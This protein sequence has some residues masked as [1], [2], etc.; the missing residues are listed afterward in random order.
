VYCVVQVLPQTDQLIQC[1][2]SQLSANSKFF[3]AF[4]YGQSQKTMRTAIWDALIQLSQGIHDIWCVLGDF[5]SIL[6]VGDRVWR[7]DILS[8]KIRE[9][10]NHLKACELTEMISIGPYFWPANKT[11]LSR[12]GKAL[13]NPL[14]HGNFDFHQV[15]YVANRLS[16]HATLLISFQTAQNTG[17][18]SPFVTCCVV[19]IVFYNH[20]QIIRR[21][22]Y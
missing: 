19:T 7:D 2:V 16:N 4:V 14:W 12:I 21:T 13:V 18:S 8:S 15:T 20:W 11:S 10:A 17:L 5:N 6:I 22:D 3:I 9:I 1:H